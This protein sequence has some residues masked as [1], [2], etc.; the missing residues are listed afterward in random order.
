MFRQ[1]V[2][3]LHQTDGE[4][5]L[6]VNVRLWRIPGCH[7]LLASLGFDLA[8]VG[9]ED[10]ILR[11][12]KTANKRQIQF[13]LQA[14]LA[15]FD[16]QDA[17][18]CIEIEEEEEDTDDE[19]EPN[20]EEQQ[21]RDGEDETS[22]SFSSSP[23][24]IEMAVVAASSTAGGQDT[25]AAAPRNS[26]AAAAA[27]FESGHASAFTSY[28]K[29]RGEPDGRQAHDSPPPLASFA[30]IPP[31]PLPQMIPIYHNDTGNGSSS[32]P[33][34][35]ESD[36][37]FTPSPVIDRAAVAAV[38]RRQPLFPAVTQALAGAY[39]YGMRS[40]CA[41]PTPPP[42][43]P[44]DSIDSLQSPVYVPLYENSEMTYSARQPAGKPVMPIRSVFTDV[45]Y[46]SAQ[47]I[48]DKSDP[49]DKFRVRAETRK[50]LLPPPPTLSCRQSSL[51]RQ[52]LQAAAAVIETR[53]K[54]G[55]TRRIPP[56]GES[57]SPDNTHVLNSSRSSSSAR[58]S[59]LS[60][61]DTASIVTTSI[62]NTFI[63]KSDDS[64]ASATRGDLPPG[65]GGGLIDESLLNSRHEANQPRISEVYHES[66]NVGLGLAPPLSSLLMSSSIK[67]VQVDHHSDSEG[68]S[69]SR[70]SSMKRNLTP[71]VSSATLEGGESV[72]PTKE[73]EVEEEEEDEEESLNN[74]DTLSVVE[75]A[76][77]ATPSKPSNYLQLVS[78][79]RK[80]PVLPKPDSESP[81]LKLSA[82]AA[83]LRTRDDGDGRSMTDSQYSGYSPNGHP[84]KQQR[85]QMSFGAAASGHDLSAKMSYL[86]LKRDNITLPEEKEPYHHRQQKPTAI[87]SA[88]GKQLKPRDIADYIN[89]EFRMPTSASTS[90]VGSSTRTQSPI[91]VSTR[92]PHHIW[93]R[94]RNGGLQYTG[95][96][97]S[98][99]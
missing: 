87:L 18:R 46:Q 44:P 6:P 60:M 58:R 45:G 17:P 29:N 4:S 16:T 34:G 86:K 3:V 47:K 1:I 97:S 53:L 5:M 91:A 64:A 90:A 85:R 65:A 43:P 27:I 49:T 9:S 36:C 24:P 37:N 11:T 95:M 54:P 55:V 68:G 32:H 69:T 7:E 59:S 72:M 33:K 78:P 96:L 25:F 99:C 8:E 39:T 70:T 84:K 14:L 75:M 82:L 23:S 20:E 30:H 94:D 28:V 71:I 89:K 57:E 81:N 63:I 80:P 74:I 12:G 41:Q 21:Q 51:Q 93:S 62:A 77:K 40:S 31:P 15:V 73:D 98:D 10:V 67:V 83:V 76:H 48:T 92:H 56:T 79:R 35:H 19:L 88:A 26:A 52:Q 38:N 50:T 66:R 2:N 61:A 13:A 42:P 22:G